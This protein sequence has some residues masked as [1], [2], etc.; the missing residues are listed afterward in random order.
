MKHTLSTITAAALLFVFYTDW[1]KALLSVIVLACLA[2]IG[3]VA[4]AVF[5]AFTQ[6]SDT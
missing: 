1:A 4:V 6:K 3:A 5:R 2:I